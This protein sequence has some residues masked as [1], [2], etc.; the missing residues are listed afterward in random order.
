ML[1]VY[2]VSDCIRVSKQVTRDIVHWPFEHDKKS[3]K[4]GQ[5]TRSKFWGKLEF[6]HPFEHDKKSRKKGQ[7]TRSKFWGK[8]FW[9]ISLW[10]YLVVPKDRCFDC[11]AAVLV[12]AL[13][14]VHVE[15]LK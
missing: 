5:T 6:L 14:D 13:I 4:K 7:T 1:N 11:I 12:E 15:I 10:E 9:Y 2:K 8:R 3:R